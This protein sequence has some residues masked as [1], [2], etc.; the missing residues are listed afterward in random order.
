MSKYLGLFVS[1]ATEHLEA[2]GR[3]LVKLEQ[4]A[5]A[6]IDDAE[7]FAR[8]SPFPQPETA[9]DYVYA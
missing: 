2:L 1:E 8:S 4:Q 9:L 5:M 6:R 7:Q 3:D